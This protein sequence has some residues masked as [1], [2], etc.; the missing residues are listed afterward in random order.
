MSK[1]FSAAGALFALVTIW[2]YNW[3]V[4]KV[5]VQ[6]ASPFD[7]AAMRAFFAGIMLLLVMMWRHQPLLPKDIPGTF[8][9]GILQTSGVL[10]LSMWA[11]VSGGAGKTAILNYTMP[12]WVLLLAW[13]LLGEQIRKLQWL[14]VAVAFSGLLCIL[15]PLDLSE[16]LLSKGLALLS[17]ISWAIGAVLAKRLQQ[18]SKLNVLSFTTWQMLFGSIPLILAAVLVPAQPITWSP[19]FIAALLYNIIPGNAIAWLLW[20]YAL[21]QLS[22]GTAGLGM[23]ATPVIGVLAAWIQLGE[24]PATLELVGMF[25]IVLALLLNAVQVMK[26]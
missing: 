17:G 13:L 18:K 2:G 6:Y 7:F 3:V 22:A 14:S 10:G 19:A 20:F 5:G 15:M 12:F 16:G 9:V 1:P 24:T 26:R 4:M 21:S 8:L 25:L 23:L 11:L